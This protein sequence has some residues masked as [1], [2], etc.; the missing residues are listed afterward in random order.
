MKKRLFFTLVLLALASL[1][2]QTILGS[3]TPEPIN[4]PAPVDD[5]SPPPADT[6]SAPDDKM[7][8]LAFQDDFSDTSSGWDRSEWDNGV[9]DYAN[10]VYEILVKAPKYDIWANPQLYF[11]DV[12]VEVDFTKV[13]GPEEND[14]GLICRYEQTE[15][16][17]SFYYG[18]VGSDGYAGIYKVVDGEPAVLKEKEP[19]SVQAVKAG[20][21]P[22]HIRLDCIGN[23][24]T[25]FVNG[26]KVM[27]AADYDLSAGDVGLIA[28]VYDVA[29]LRVQFDDFKVYTP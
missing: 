16:A 3:S 13:E 1:A 4:Q 19:G 23:R 24:I 11:T 26:A 22:N 15:E 12:R 5:N 29:G 20:S 9:T 25:L 7:T 6:G 2:C 10:G 14:I 8:T 28:G 17:Y 27:A 18:V 21:A